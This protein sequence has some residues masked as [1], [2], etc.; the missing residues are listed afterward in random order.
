MSCKKISGNPRC[1]Y[2][3][4]G[5]YSKKQTKD[6]IQKNIEAVSCLGAYRLAPT[7]MVND[8]VHPNM[9]PEKVVGLIT[10]LRGEC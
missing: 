6:E 2:E 9:T 10:E 1:I 3:K 5:F 7:F 4:I 8:E